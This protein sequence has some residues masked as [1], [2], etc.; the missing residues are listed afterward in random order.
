MAEPVDLLEKLQ[1]TQGI[2]LDL[3]HDLSANPVDS[4]EE[5]NLRTVCEIQALVGSGIHKATILIENWP[6]E[7][8]P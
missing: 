4:Q 7:P 3:I 5:R 6:E 2:A 1:D 8:P